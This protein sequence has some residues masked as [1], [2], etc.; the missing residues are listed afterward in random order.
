ME[1]SILWRRL[2]LSGHEHLRVLQGRGGWMLSGVAVVHL[3]HMPCRLDYTIQ[4]DEQW[5]TLG[6][7]VTGW[8][9][10]SPVSIRVIVDGQ[11]RWYVNGTI[12]PEL[13]GC[14]DLDL[15]FSP[16]TNLLPIRRLGLAVGEHAEVTAAWL[17]FP[18]LT[19]EPLVQTYRRQDEFTYRYE[20]GGGAFVAD[21]TVNSDGLVTLYPDVWIAETAHAKD[22]R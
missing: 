16:A 6:G 11:G 1:L 8:I 5:K 10:D 18:E 13:A 3:D 2:D 14:V 22:R 19:F 20:S 4:C 12:L 15:N 7:R 21:L 9:G 17:R